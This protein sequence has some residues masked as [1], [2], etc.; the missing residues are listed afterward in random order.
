MSTEIQKFNDFTNRIGLQDVATW[1]CRTGPG[2]QV[3]SAIYDLETANRIAS[4][5]NKALQTVGGM[6]VEVTSSR[7]ET[8]YRVLIPYFSVYSIFINDYLE[9]NPK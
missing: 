8:G 9:K 4:V 7:T 1:E 6:P 3:V 5:V 2:N